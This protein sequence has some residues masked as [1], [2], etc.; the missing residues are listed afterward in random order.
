VGI[1]YC[2]ISL[3]LLQKGR[4]VYGVIY[5]MARRI[6]IHGGPAF[7]AFDG[8]QPAHARSDAPHANS[9]LGFHSPYDH[10]LV[11]RVG[12]VIA[13]F[14]IRGLGSSALHLAYVGI[15]LLDGVLDVNVRVWDIAAAHAIALGGGAEIHYLRNNPFP[16]REF[17]LNMPRIQYVAGN[18]KVC[19][20]V[21]A[22][23][24]A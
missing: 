24:K 9:L 4:P 8:S 12:P 20:R 21:R 6:L 11:P 7:G 2:A 16:L 17:D 3:A 5:D 22:L 23:L 18:A 10:S 19:A 14:K 13:K 1:P 15:G